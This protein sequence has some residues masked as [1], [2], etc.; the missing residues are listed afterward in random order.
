MRVVAAGVDTLELHTVAAVRRSVVDELEHLKAL[1]QG[2]P[3]GERGPTWE[4]A[5]Q[6][7]EVQ[8]GGGKRGSLLLVSDAMAVSIAPYAPDNLPTVTVELRARHLWQDLDAAA[9]DAEEV[10][11]VLTHG[12]T[13][14][15]QV[16]RLDVTA[17]WQG[18]VPEGALVDSWVTRARRDAAYRQHREHSGWS[19][20]GGGAIYGRC[21]DKTLEIAG[22]EKADWF[23]QVWAKSEAYLRIEPVWRME[24]QVRREALRELAPLGFDADGLLKTW[25]GARERLGDLFSTLADGW[26]SLRVPGSATRRS[27]WL[28]DPRWE[29]L[30]S[31]AVFGLA[32]DLRAPVD[33]AR[34]QAETE[35]RRTL[36][37]L[38]G[39]VARGIAERWALRGT[40]E[41][42]HV[43]YE[44]LWSDV[45]HHLSRKGASLEEKVADLYEPLLF[46]AR[47]VKRR[48]AARAQG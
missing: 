46:Q 31:R 10:C 35:F 5:G 21:Y 20:G 42:H 23:P 8:R 24:F 16:S 27:R 39:Y 11:Q 33:L 19:W 6:A 13:A 36:D 30:R 12:D 14:E 25:A 17:D 32:R 37:Q 48:A 9:Q 7:L 47:A 4:C 18:W 34:V 29:A 41:S 44:R 45:C 26:L 1:A 15:V 40:E 3:K 2:S 22:T 38:A 43:T 28:V